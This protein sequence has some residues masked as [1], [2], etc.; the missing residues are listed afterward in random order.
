MKYG[1]C[2]E[3][4]ARRGASQAVTRTADT[5]APPSNIRPVTRGNPDSQHRVI[6]VT[7]TG[8]HSP[9]M[10]AISLLENTNEEA[11]GEEV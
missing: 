8:G 2:S 9:T 4:R 11:E 5:G 6:T 3:R 10:V 7:G 1:H